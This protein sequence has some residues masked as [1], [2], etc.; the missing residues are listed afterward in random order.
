MNEERIKEVFSN[1]EFVKDLFASASFEDAQKKLADKDVDMSIDELKKAFQLVQLRQNGNL[2]DE[3]LEAVAGGII[4]CLIVFGI[5]SVLSAGCLIA[6][7]KAEKSG[8]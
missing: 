2:S 6:A 7:D 3:E 4:G 8:C 5:C 1:E